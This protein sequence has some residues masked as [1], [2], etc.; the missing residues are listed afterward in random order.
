MCER[1]SA[2]SS[3]KDKERELEYETFGWSVAGLA[4]YYPGIR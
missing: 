4:D 1:R 2:P 3:E